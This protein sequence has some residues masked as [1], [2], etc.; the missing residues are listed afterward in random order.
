MSTKQ[1]IVEATK[2]IVAME[3]FEGFNVRKLATVAHLSPSHLY[4]YTKDTRHLFKEVIDV[5]AQ[6]LGRKR[7]ALPGTRSAAEML[8]QRIHFQ[9]DNADDVIYI[10]KYYIT[11]RDEFIQNSGGYVPHTAYKHILEVLEFGQQNNEWIITDCVKEAK[12]ITHAINGFVL[13]Y[14]P[15]I[16]TGKEKD[17]LVQDI[18]QFLLKAL[19][20]TKASY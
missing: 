14:Y 20:N 5:T 10:L 4:Y 8:S 12:V 13:E 11:F 19:T 7:A 2:K 1:I 9:F 3:S 17:Q 18:Q 15:H 16:P 6:E